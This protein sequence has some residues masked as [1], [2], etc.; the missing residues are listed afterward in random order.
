MFNYNLQN[1][2]ARPDTL[3]NVSSFNIINKKFPFIE[4][5][6]CSDIEKEA[7]RNKIKYEGMT[8]MTIGKLNDYIDS[9]IDGPNYF[10]GQLI[11]ALD[12]VDDFHI[13]DAIGVEL[14]KGIYLGS[15]PGAHK[16]ASSSGEAD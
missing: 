14:E 15:S 9:P 2:A 16:S 1:I 10:K 7:L 3:V 6:T 4:Y 11:Q 8:I 12:V 5:Y 13:V